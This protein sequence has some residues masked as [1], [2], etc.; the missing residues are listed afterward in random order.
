MKQKISLALAAV[1]AMCISIT[2][3]AHHG[4]P[5]KFRSEKI[6]F[7]TTELNLTPAEAEKF[8]PVYNQ[9]AEEKKVALE[10]VIKAYKELDEAVKNK[11]AD[12]EIGKLTKAYVEANSTFQSI[13]GKYLKDLQ[14]VLPA[15]KVAKLFLCEEK[16]R[17]QQIHRLGKNNR[18]PG[19]DGPDNGQ[20]PQ[21]PGN[22]RK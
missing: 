18:G 4:D 21:R 2:A 7:I 14:K 3:S 13:D 1:A 15:E 9:V 20:R 8:W 12:A 5:D 11:A 16:F 17:R 22:D 10:A 19:Q 6:A